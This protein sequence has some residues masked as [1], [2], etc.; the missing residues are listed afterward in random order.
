M[1]PVASQGPRSRVQTRSGGRFLFLLELAPIS[2]P[3]LTRGPA[4]CSRKGWTISVV[5]IKGNPFSRGSAQ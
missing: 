2:T 3:V 1:A 4:R 5:A